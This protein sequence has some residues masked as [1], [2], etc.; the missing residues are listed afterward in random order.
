LLWVWVM[1][2]LVMANVLPETWYIRFG[3]RIR[4]A[5]A[6]AAAFVFAYLFMNGQQ[7]VFLY[8]QF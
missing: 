8:Y 3:T 2:C 6:Y 1:L 7:T 5:V 4:W